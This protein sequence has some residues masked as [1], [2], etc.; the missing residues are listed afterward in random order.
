MSDPISRARPAGVGDNPAA[1]SPADNTGVSLRSSQRPTP[2][3]KTCE[4][5]VPHGIPVARDNSGARF[6]TAVLRGLTEWNLNSNVFHAASLPGHPQRKMI[7]RYAAISAKLSGF[8]LKE[9]VYTCETG[10]PGGALQKLCQGTL[11]VDCNTAIGM[12]TY[13]TLLEILG[14]NDF[15]RYVDMTC[16]NGI[17]KIDQATSAHLGTLATAFYSQRA[18][19]IENPFSKEKFSV[20]DR[21]GIQGPA[22]GFAF[23][24]AGENNFVNVVVD[25]RHRL[26]AF[27]SKGK[28]NSWCYDELK[29]MLL[30]EYNAPLT[31]CDLFLMVEAA[32][33][34]PGDYPP[35][36]SWTPIMAFAWL[37]QTQPEALD[38]AMKMML[39]DPLSSQPTRLLP[40]PSSGIRG[41]VEC[42]KAPSR[43]SL[44]TLVSTPQRLASEALNDPVPEDIGFDV[45]LPGFIAEFAHQKRI[46][47]AVGTLL[48]M[49]SR[50]D[51]ENSFAGVILHGDPGT[52]KSVAM[53]KTIA[54]LEARG[55]SIWRSLDK[56]LMT[57]ASNEFFGDPSYDP[58]QGI[59]ALQAQLGE[60]W[61][62][63]DVIVIDDLHPKSDA[64]R[65]GVQA[66]HNAALR[67]ARSHGKKIFLI[68]EGDPIGS[69]WSSIRF[70]V[71]D[72]SIWKIEGPP[73]R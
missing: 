60:R 65:K 14:E 6:N 19:Q 40:P 59:Q 24:F 17:L 20:G 36:A 71:D 34:N 53:K 57:S 12:L 29:E 11:V 52:G 18:M 54:L 44:A 22:E 68:V 23:H 26:V 21:L 5:R 48:A 25:D 66:L 32:R 50:P 1:H 28:R 2:T 3:L 10:N 30:K 63:V 46:L 15:N 39:A 49:C 58:E 73:F 61:R 42:T 35:Y 43:V 45:P 9:S 8:T 4:E 64:Q 37:K 51:L 69:L 16:P 56:M 31:C 72:L 47:A 7:H 33:E 62:A 38:E 55:K 13:R 27:A 67:C 70:P 41:V